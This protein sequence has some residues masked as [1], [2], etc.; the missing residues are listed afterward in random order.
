MQACH[1]KAMG[2]VKGEM[3][4][5]VFILNILAP[6]FGTL[7]YAFIQEGGMNKDCLVLALVHIFLAWTIIVWILA[8]YFGYQVWQKYK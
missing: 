3:A 1:D 2:Q 6:G 8:I 5:L 4:M 7:I